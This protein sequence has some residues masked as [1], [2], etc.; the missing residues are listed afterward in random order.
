M[1]TV[2]EANEVKDAVLEAIG[3]FEIANKR[4]PTEI[5]ISVF[6]AN[7]LVKL[8]YQEVGPISQ[9]LFLQGTAFFDT[10]RLYGCSVTV[11]RYMTKDQPPICS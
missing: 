8:T 4:R 2:I 9:D 6:M 11:D 3:S 1:A 10:N 7:D 5:R